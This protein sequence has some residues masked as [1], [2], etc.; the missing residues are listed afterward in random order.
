MCHDFPQV[1]HEKCLE[2]GISRKVIRFMCEE[3]IS[4]YGSRGLSLHVQ[5][6]KLLAPI[7]E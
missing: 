2:E 4:D 1:F 6:V 3:R 5:T 7:D